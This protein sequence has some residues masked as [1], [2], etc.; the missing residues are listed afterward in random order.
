MIVMKLLKFLAVMLLDALIMV[1]I[2]AFIGLIVLYCFNTPYTESRLE[3][4]NMYDDIHN[5][6]FFNDFPEYEFLADP[7]YDQMK[8]FLNEDKV[9]KNKPIRS[10]NE[11]E[12]YVCRHFARDVLVHAAQKNIRAGYVRLDYPDNKV[13]IIVAFDT[14]DKGL[15]FVDPQNDCEYHIVVGGKY[16]RGKQTNLFNYSGVMVYKLIIPP[17]LYDSLDFSYSNDKIE[18]VDIYWR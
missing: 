16:W 17:I 7:T 5:M 10:D 6:Y 4:V 14:V 2:T 18:G 12:E 11:E 9:D 3:G 1:C 8:D 13:H 15:I